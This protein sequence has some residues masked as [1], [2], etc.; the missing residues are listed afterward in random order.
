MAACPPRR[1]G[2]HEALLLARTTR[3]RTR[4]ERANSSPAGFRRRTGTHVWSPDTGLPLRPSRA[5]GRGSGRQRTPGTGEDLGDLVRVGGLLV[6]SHQQSQALGPHDLSCR[7]ERSPD[8]WPHPG[9]KAR[10][11]VSVGGDQRGWGWPR[12]RQATEWP[13]RNRGRASTPTI[14]RSSKTDARI[15]RARWSWGSSNCGT[16]TA[17]STRPY[18]R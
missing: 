7:W 16:M 14:S 1:P 5:A 8:C 10:A 4:L 3:Q 2:L 18:P 6:E 9:T 13:A 15:S 11:G 12:R 17:P